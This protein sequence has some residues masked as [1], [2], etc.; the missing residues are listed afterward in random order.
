MNREAAVGAEAQVAA[1]MQQPDLALLKPRD[2]FYAGHH[3]L[4]SD[5]LLIIEVSDTTVQYDRTVKTP[6]YAQAGILEMWL[7][8]LP[9]DTIDVCANPADGQYQTVQHLKRGDTLTSPTIPDLVLKVDD[10]LG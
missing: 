8:D 2:D 3:P 9:A 7:I 10:I 1:I 4:P 5:V 6:L